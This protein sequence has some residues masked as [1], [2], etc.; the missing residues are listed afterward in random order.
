M[1]T[2]RLPS[3]VRKILARR[4]RSRVDFMLSKIVV[5]DDMK[6][7]DIGCGVDGR[8]FEDYLPDGWRVTGVDIL[9]CEQVH[10]EYSGFSYLQQDARDLSCFR[11]GEFD[12]AVSIGMMEHITDELVFRQIVSEMMR[13]AKQYIVVVPYRYAWIE[14]HY[15]VPFF[16][17][18]PYS[19]KLA[20][21]KLF[22]LSNHRKVVREDP[23]Y[24][25]R[26]F[27]W[28]SNSQYKAEFPDSNIYLLPTLEMIAITRRF[29]SVNVI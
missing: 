26:N 29:S 4:R 9:P 3:F 28:L 21:V 8:S 23:E 2:S 5:T 20:I 19:M 6:V 27:R 11:D 13:V 25:N 16:P 17:V 14:P 1:E 7:L 24:I 22:N 18:F 15:G 10:H 12:L